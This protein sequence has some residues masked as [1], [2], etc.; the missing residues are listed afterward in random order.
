MCKPVIYLYPQKPT[1]MT[2]KVLPN[3]GFTYTKPLYK[4]G[5]R[6][7]AYPDGTVKNLADG[8]K[9]P[10]L[11]W[12]GI[13]LNYPEQ[14]SGF[15]VKQS[16]LK[17]FFTNKLSKLGLVGREAEDFKDYWIPRLKGLDKPYYKI[18]FLKKEQMD[19]IAPLELSVK[20]NSVIR[21][22]MTAKGLEEFESLPKQELPMPA[23]RAGFVLAEWGGAILK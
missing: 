15:I 12:E 10:Y 22:M 20:P 18:S 16:E 23:K 9:Y 5:W 6:V 13:G 7:V 8:E 19:E 1:E 3:G 21:V 17:T 14:I 2:V 11:F 4:N